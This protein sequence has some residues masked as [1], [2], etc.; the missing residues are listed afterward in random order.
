MR[1]EINKPRKE[2]MENL[3]GENRPRREEKGKEKRKRKKGKPNKV[4][5]KD[6][7]ERRK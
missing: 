2:I 3:K 4:R 1:K 7:G 6:I 5:G